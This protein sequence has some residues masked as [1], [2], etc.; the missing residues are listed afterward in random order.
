MKMMKE[1]STT[2]PGNR[3]SEEGRFAKI[4]FFYKASKR[5]VFIIILFNYALSFNI[6][7]KEINILKWKWVSLMIWIFIDTFNMPIF[8]N[9]IFLLDGLGLGVKGT[10]RHP[11]LFLHPRCRNEIL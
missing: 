11:T 9:L 5:E 2:Y 4:H 8:F 3:K 7:K 6:Q 10:I 1:K